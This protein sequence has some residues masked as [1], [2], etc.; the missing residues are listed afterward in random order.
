MLKIEDKKVLFNLKRCTQCGACIAACEKGALST[1][2]ADN[3]LYSI[4]VNERLC[5]CCGRCVTVCPSH[6]LP[7]EKP[8]NKCWQEIIGCVLSYAKDNEIRKNASSGGVARMLLS[9][10]LSKGISESAYCLRY[11]RDYPWAEGYL[12]KGG[13]TLEDV[14]NSMYLPILTMKNLRF[15]KPLESILLIGTTCQLLAATRL[16][17]GRV[18]KIIQIAIFCKQQK[19]IGLT[20]FIAKRLGIQFEQNRG[21]QMS[22]RG[23]GW[24]G[25]ITIDE[26]EISFEEAASLPYGKRLWRVPGCLCCPNPFGIGV[27]LTLADP[28]GLEESGALGKTLVLIW[29]EQGKKLLELNRDLL[30]EESID[31]PS[32]K[33]SIGWQALEHRRVLVD[34]Y[35]GAEVPFRVICAGVAERISTRIYEATLESMNLPDIL[36]KVM[37]HIP[38]AATLVLGCVQEGR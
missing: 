14:P 3:G 27:D 30:I 25:R 16:L 6:R 20:K 33:K 7:N 18:N 31:I 5:D 13:V 28:W 26:K 38:D 1:K 4:A 22:Y 34:Y 12:W 17:N 2:V 36:Y 32:V 24:P 21:H 9:G 10:T 29:T 19:T 15:K 37:A 35:A 23:K 11:I 8:L